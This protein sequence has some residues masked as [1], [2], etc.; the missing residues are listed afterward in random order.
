MKKFVTLFVVAVFGSLLAAVPASAGEIYL[1]AHIDPRDKSDISS[2][3]YLRKAL[4]NGGRIEVNVDVCKKVEPAFDSKYPTDDDDGR[5]YTFP[6][7]MNFIGDHGWKLRL[8][9]GRTYIFVK[10]KGIF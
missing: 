8:V 2:A 5:Y 1:L 10:E 7:I 9:D 6:A 3:S 4:V